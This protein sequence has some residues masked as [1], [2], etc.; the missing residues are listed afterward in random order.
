MDQLFTHRHDKQRCL[1]ILKDLLAGFVAISDAL[2]AL[3]LE[4]LCEL[5]PEAVV[6]C[7]TRDKKK[8]WKSMEQVSNNALTWWLVL[9]L[10]PIPGWR[11]FPNIASNANKRWV[12]VLLAAELLKSYTPNPRLFD[13][14]FLYSGVIRWWRPE[15]EI[16]MVLASQK[17]CIINISREQ[18]H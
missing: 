1:K 13:N 17:V 10:W 7:V 2:G 12:N 6:I 14:S 8:W 16:C 4:E 9:L 3:F 18:L 15:I 11:W 5:Y